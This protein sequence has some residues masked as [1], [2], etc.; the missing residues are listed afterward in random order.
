M[1][2]RVKGQ[3]FTPDFLKREIE[4]EE[5]MA[6]DIL[7]DDVF[8]PYPDP[9]FTFN[10]FLEKYQV[11]RFDLSLESSEVKKTTFESLL[12]SDTS[13]K[14]RT[15]SDIVGNALKRISVRIE[16]DQWVRFDELPSKNKR[17][18]RDEVSKDIVKLIGS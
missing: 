18:Y 3:G 4:L 14:R 16:G 6:R 13:V 9:K 8:L 1:A 2:E 11:D 15:A 7:N 10:H 12:L 17:Y 5:R